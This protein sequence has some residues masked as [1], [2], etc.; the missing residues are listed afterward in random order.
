MSMS[1]TYE[2]VS[3]AEKLSGALE[4]FILSIEMAIDDLS[5]T[6]KS[7]VDLVETCRELIEEA[8]KRKG[9][10]DETLAEAECEESR[11]LNRW[12]ERSAV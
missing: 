11:E 10:A 3:K 8:K 7:L 1:M 2:R 4:S 5:G 6:G 9:E 12:F